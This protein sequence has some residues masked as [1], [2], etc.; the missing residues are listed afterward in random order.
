MALKQNLLSRTIKLIWKYFKACCGQWSG[1]KGI[2]CMQIISSTHIKWLFC[3]LVI[4]LWPFSTL[5]QHLYCT[6][7]FTFLWTTLFLLM[8][9]AWG[10]ASMCEA[11]GMVG[12]AR[13]FT[14]LA[15]CDGAEGV[16]T[17]ATLPL[18][19]SSFPANNSS[20]SFASWNIVFFMTKSVPY[21]MSCI[22][23]KGDVH[24]D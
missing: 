11:L 10:T 14:T 21:L 22:Q 16:S 3:F 9:V 19:F 15:L 4:G 5:F 18:N 12:K 17:E 23:L 7:A 24:L 20:T 2:T 1:L 13:A 6:L 8:G